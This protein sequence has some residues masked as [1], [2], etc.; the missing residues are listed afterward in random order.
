MTSKAGA[1][2]LVC[3]NTFLRWFL[4]MVSRLGHVW[5][6]KEND[7]PFTNGELACA[8][9]AKKYGINSRT[10]EIKMKE[11][12]EGQEL[13]LAIFVCLEYHL[14]LHNYLQ[15]G[16]IRLIAMPSLLLSFDQNKLIYLL[17]IINLK[18]INIDCKWL[19]LSKLTRNTERS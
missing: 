16:V 11:Y 7:S 12:K 14:R 2:Q 15:E 17:I 5:E 1:C 4:T 10:E 18:S 9:E 6:Q 19:Q 13:G 8:S 3:V